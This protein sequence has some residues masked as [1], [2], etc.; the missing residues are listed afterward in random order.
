MRRAALSIALLAIANTALAQTADP[1]HTDNPAY[2]MQAPAAAVD[3]TAPATTTTTTTVISNSPNAVSAPTAPV[4]PIAP[5]VGTSD[6]AAIGNTAQPQPSESEQLNGQLTK[7]LKTK[8]N[9][10]ALMEGIA[11]STLLGCASK[12]AGQQATQDFYKQMQAVGKQVGELCKQGQATQARMLV[13]S[14]MKANQYNRVVMA[15]NSCYVAQKSNFDAMAGQ[16]LASD[17]DRYARWIR[18]PYTAQREM[19][20]SDIC[21]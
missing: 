18:D 10:Q 3:S 9:Q 6:A 5:S 21:K 20:D 16:E 19:K 1:Y 15:I 14:T 17:A 12:N 11:I 8:T 4:A 7:L 13:L 2:H